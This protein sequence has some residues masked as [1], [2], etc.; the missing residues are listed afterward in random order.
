MRCFL[1]NWYRFQ[2]ISQKITAW[3]FL[4]WSGAATMNA[5][6]VCWFWTP[7]PGLNWVVPNSAH[8]VRCPSAFMDGSSTI[9]DK[10]HWTSLYNFY[11]YIDLFVLTWFLWFQFNG[12]A[13]LFLL[14]YIFKKRIEKETAFYAISICYFANLIIQAITMALHGV[15][16]YPTRHHS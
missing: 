11:S 7:S 10:S 4:R 14:E 8:P 12:V 9:A 15:T 2:W 1:Q 16:G 6:P 5:G 3:C 13:I